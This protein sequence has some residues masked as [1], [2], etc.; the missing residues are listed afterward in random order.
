M[1]V[2]MRRMRWEKR[3]FFVLFVIFCLLSYFDVVEDVDVAPTV[4]T[5]VGDCCLLQLSHS[6]EMRVIMKNCFLLFWLI[7]ILF[8]AGCNDESALPDEAVADLPTAVISVPVQ[9]APTVTT[10]LTATFAPTA[11]IFPNTPT[12]LAVATAEPTAVPTRIPP[13][14]IPSD[15]EIVTDRRPLFLRDLL[16]I[17]DG[18]LKKWHHQSGEVE[19][20]LAPNVSGRR[21]LIY[22]DVTNFSV[23]RAGVNAIVVRQLADDSGFSELVFVNLATSEHQ[24]LVESVMNV[25]ELDM[26]PDGRYAVYVE[27]GLADDFIGG[28][29]LQL[30][31][32]SGHVMPVGFCDHAPP[33]ETDSMA[34]AR[35][36]CLGIGWTPDSQ[37]ML[38]SDTHGVWLRHIQADEPTLIRAASYDLDSEYGLTRY[39]MRDWA[40]DGRHLLLYA[41]HTYGTQTAVLDV[42]TNLLILMPDS[43]VAHFGEDA[44]YIQID[45]MQDDRLMVFRQNQNSELDPS[46]ELWRLAEGQ[47]RLEEST[48]LNLPSHRWL[49][50]P[51]HFITGRFALTLFADDVEAQ[52]IYLMASSN[53]QPKKVNELPYRNGK[54]TW[55]FDNLGT[56]YTNDRDAFMFLAVDQNGGE[57]MYDIRPFVGNIATN[58]MWLP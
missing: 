4:H 12:P 32:N 43:Y 49:G 7:I 16:F 56:I 31:I 41:H 14:V 35:N 26:S 3:P 40:K 33:T 8:G 19:I 58:F 6:I 1:V 17:G 42:A 23:D 30:E 55:L 29:I 46:L 38:W 5:V 11:V 27:Q 28:T 2:R 52:G 25:L 39:E 54:T 13:T 51:V 24:I 50:D 37:N 44:K 57:V 9:T 53:E 34:E 47:L 18:A 45:W 22:G 20:L 21:E 10:A 48:V 36:R 15:V